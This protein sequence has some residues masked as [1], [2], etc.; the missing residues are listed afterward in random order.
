MSSFMRRSLLSAFWIA[1]IVSGLVFVGNMHFC[2]AQNDISTS[3][4]AA[5]NASEGNGSLE[6]SLTIDKTS[7]SLGE[8]VNLTLFITNISNQTINYTHTGLDFDFQVI[9]G[10]NNVVY[11]W[12][13]F[14][15]IAQ[16][17]AIIPLSAGES[18]S[19]NFTWQQICNF[20]TQVEGYPVSPGTYN[21]VGETGPT[22]R[23]QTAPIQI[24]IGIAPTVIST[25]TP[26]PTPT[27]TPPAPNLDVSCQSSVSYSNFKVEITGSLSFKGAGI[28]GVPIL[29]SY[30]VNDGNSW[31]DLA[32]AS[33]DSNGNFAVVWF[34]T[35]SGTYLLNAQWPGN[36]TLSVANK[37]INLAILP[38]QDQSI[39]SVSS[40]STFSA[41]AFNSTSKELSFSVSGP[42]DT[43]GYVDIYIPKSLIIDTSNL[44]VYLDGNQ[45][46]FTTESQGDS[47]LLS[48]NYHHS[49]HQVTIN[50][51][52][53]SSASFNQNQLREMIIIGIAISAMAMVVAIL[54]LRKSKK[55]K[56][57]LQKNE[58]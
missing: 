9:N 53:E 58:I 47:W 41:F 57:P 46:N 13:N 56:T 44:K 19:A 14:R 43:T 21:I 15:A 29:L 7:Y 11:Q 30:S 16:F 23:I 49:T 28:S 50:L 22:Y 39:F 51:G 38:Y 4:P 42:S 54:S 6:L 27:S 48:F 32:T 2:D 55:T 52:S 35:V 45:L 20:N 17:L 18:T 8:P 12:S 1:V 10:T 34:P 25:P 5:T 24:T 36:S 37:T 33:S 31:I 40:N 26:T 3:I